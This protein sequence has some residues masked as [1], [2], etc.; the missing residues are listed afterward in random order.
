[1]YRFNDAE[2]GLFDID[3]YDVTEID[4]ISSMDFGDTKLDKKDK[5]L[6]RSMTL[7]KHLEHENKRQRSILMALMDIEQSRAFR[8]LH[9]LP[10]STTITEKWNA[11]RQVFYPLM[12]FH[13]AFMSILTWS[14][15]ERA[16]QDHNANGS[17]DI[18][19]APM[20]KRKPDNDAFT[21]AASIIGIIVAVIYLLQEL[22]RILFGKMPYHL[23][24][25]TNPYNNSWFRIMI[26]IFSVS[27]IADFPARYAVYY[28]NYCLIAAVILGW[29]LMI[30]FLRASRPFGFFTLLIQRVLLDIGRFFVIIALEILAFGTVIYMLIQG[31][32]VQNSPEYSNYLKVLA[33]MIELMVGLGE[34]PDFY[35]LR[36]SVTAVIIFITFIV[37]TTLLLI[38]ALI[39][40]MSDT[41]TDLVQNGGSHDHH[42]IMQRLSTVLFFES[43]MPNN[44]IK[45]IGVQK[46]FF[47]FNNELDKRSQM[48]RYMKTIVSLEDD[49]MIAEETGVSS[50]DYVL[51]RLETYLHKQKK[52]PVTKKKGRNSTVQ[53]TSK[54]ETLKSEPG[55]LNNT[56]DIN[57]VNYCQRCSSKEIMETSAPQGQYSQTI[58]S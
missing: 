54:A 15:V 53:P 49:T 26:I 33:A 52:K 57:F 38:N 20:L 29:F 55:T 6:Y 32:D 3:V 25:F 39:A 28:E 16:Q 27:L 48:T 19:A 40:L 18:Y 23:R 7:T 58:L 9:Y 11:Y 1:M 42:W 51:N 37:M 34:L 22:I 4:A 44:W 47:R 41:C 31:S 17:F 21:L 2:K 12:L 14:A 8:F 24:S 5:A 46:E 13:F 10:I 30:F 50:R 35:S 56:L 45:K 43:I 36:H